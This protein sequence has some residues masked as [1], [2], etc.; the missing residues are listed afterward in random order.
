MFKN[1]RYDKRNG[2]IEGYIWEKES[3]DRVLCIIHG[4]GEHAGRYDRMCE[5]LGQT[6]IAAVSMD[7]RGHGKSEGVRGHAAPREDVLKDVDAMIEYASEKYPGVPI[8]LYGHSMGGNICLDYRNRG[9]LNDVPVSYIVSA[10]WVKLVR[11]V[12]KPLYLGLK[13]L[14]KIAPRATMDSGCHTSDLG[15]INLVK[16]YDTDP[17]VHSKVSFKCAA[18]GYDIGVALGN[19]THPSNHRADN[20]PFLLMHGDS[21]KICSVEGSRMIAEQNRTNPYFRYIEWPGYYHEIHNGGPEAT[22]EAVIE[23][24]REFI[25]K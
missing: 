11:P 5:M 1:F 12:S 21:D 9:E 16:S 15:N 20:K 18:E 25:L 14:S 3:P 23:T 22:G 2:E 4:I 17:L 19:G 6:N 24:I 10:P 7:N 13:F 8:T